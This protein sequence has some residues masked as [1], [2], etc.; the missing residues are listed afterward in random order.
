[1]FGTWIQI[2]YEGALDEGASTDNTIDGITYGW[3]NYR[4]LIWTGN[5]LEL[6]VDGVETVRIARS[7][8]DTIIL[9]PDTYIYDGVVDPSTR[10][11]NPMTT[12]VM[13]EVTG[14]LGS[15]SSGYFWIQF[16]MGGRFYWT[17][18][19]AVDMPFTP[20]VPD[21]AYLYPYSRLYSQLRTE[22]SRLYN[23]FNDIAGRWRGLAFG[24]TG[25]TCNAIT[26][27]V[28]II[29]L[30]DNDLALE[31]IYAPPTQALREAQTAINAALVLF[32]DVCANPTQGVSPQTIQ[33][34]LDQVDAAERYLN[35]VGELIIPL[36][37]RDPILGNTV[38]P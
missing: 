9:L 8:G 19:W 3:V 29:G 23:A 36:Q 37:R 6:P 31:T 2:A 32:R 33:Q 24:T 17:A 13:V 20:R 38:T 10:I 15:V 18:S 22:S 5:I 11:Q 7:V 12:A 16:K 4:L 14:R 21:A 28:M 27:D 26:D 34:A 30:T 25:V 1:V 35:I